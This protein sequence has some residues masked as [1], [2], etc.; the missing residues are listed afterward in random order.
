MYTGDIVSERD[1]FGACR[2][3]HWA[4]TVRRRP[5]LGLREATR[6]RNVYTR[7]RFSATAEPGFA[8]NAIRVTRRLFARRTRARFP[9]RS[10]NK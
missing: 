7:V 4:G 8:R 6:A 5:S 9:H 2:G 10:S 3:N 1:P